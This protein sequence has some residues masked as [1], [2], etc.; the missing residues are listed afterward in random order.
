MNQTIPRRAL[1][2][3]IVGIGGLLTGI[4]ADSEYTIEEISAEEPTGPL[5]L[6][7]TIIDS[8]ITFDKPGEI[9]LS[10]TN[11]ADEPIELQNRGIAPFGVLTA[12]GVDRGGS[13]LT[14]YS[15]AYDEVDGV[16]STPEQLTAE[17]VVRT[18]V[19]P[20]ETASEI[21]E[22]EGSEV[23]RTGAYEIRVFRTRMPLLTYENP[24]TG[25]TVDETPSVV[26]EIDAH[27][28]VRKYLPL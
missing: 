8:E 1:L 9:E 25:E 12:V 24:E 16:E 14:L 13:G 23:L 17:E 3:S 20:D 2:G 18:T 26:F 22:I 21:Y 4:F 10:V 28:V 27:T 6:S 15:P 7:A 5:S 11:E 19:G